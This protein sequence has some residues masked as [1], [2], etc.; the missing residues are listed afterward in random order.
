[1]RAITYLMKYSG[2]WYPKEPAMREKILKELKQDWLDNFGGKFSAEWD[3]ALRDNDLERYLS[4]K[5]ENWQRF[6][7]VARRVVKGIP[8]GQ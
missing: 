4:A 1:M 7:D 3:A 8:N 2:D 5:H 6:G